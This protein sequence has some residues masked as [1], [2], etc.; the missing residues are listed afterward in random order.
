MTRTHTRSPTVIRLLAGCV[1]GGVCLAG[2]GESD[3]NTP[4]AATS[5]VPPKAVTPVNVASTFERIQS[6][7]FNVSCTSDSCHSHV[8][9]AGALILEDGYSWDA[10]INH[11]PSNPVAASN[12]LMRVMPG[13]PAAT[14]LLS[15]ITANL[16]AGEGTSM[17]YGAAPLSV[18]T[19]DVIQAWV[20][21][22]A[23]ATGRVPGDD[24]RDL[25][26]GGDQPGDVTLP[27][28]AN[29]VQ[30]AVISPPVPRGKEETG[31]HYFKLP[32]DVD[33]DV[34]RIQVAVSG[35]SHHIHLYRPTDR[36]LDVPDHYEVCNMAVDFDKWELVVGVQL[37]RTDWELPPGVAYHFRAGEQLLMQ[38]HFIN[39]GSVETL[40][41]GKVLMNLHA[42]EPGSVTDHAGSIFG[43]DKD[44]F[45][46]AHSKTTL[47][48]E[49]VF[50]KTITLMAETGHY[51]FRGREFDTYLWD[52]GI[53]GDQIYQYIGYDDP[54][55]LVHAPPIDF[56]PGGGVQWQCYWENNTDNDYS[57][58]PFTDINE[59]CNW[60]GFY[61]PTDTSDEFIT[62]VKQ[63]G[64]AVT[65]VR[66]PQ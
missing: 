51:H 2:C 57:F 16:S 61:Y 18:S 33:L 28:P 43:Q 30:L 36:T 23:P 44:V 48:A 31:C 10:L 39:V 35:G 4:G 54:P 9:Q 53:R 56:A 40:G 25:G 65:T 17:P 62:C 46:P 27:P 50:P 60:F 19:V 41:E 45:V 55:F 8:G 6:Q 64:V 37:R 14:F 63:N 32:S 58:G 47:A 12:N 5:A 34:N 22:G 1:I 21:A 42:A 3:N 26:S 15:K 52:N 13:Q 24:G 20:A 38:T 7:V 11:I 59:H 49:C 66:H 29:G